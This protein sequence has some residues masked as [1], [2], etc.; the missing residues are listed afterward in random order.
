MPPTQA[1]NDFR[2]LEQHHLSRD[3]RERRHS[4]NSAMRCESSSIGELIFGEQHKKVV[5]YKQQSEIKCTWV[6]FR[7]KAAC[8]FLGSDKNSSIRTSALKIVRDR[9]ERNEVRRTA[10]GEASERASGEANSSADV[11]PADGSSNR[12]TCKRTTR[13]QE[14]EAFSPNSVLFRG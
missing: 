12:K 9:C 14:V 4:S 5:V 2:C 10:P 11:Q 13:K 1:P 8:L 7:L 3:E 6:V